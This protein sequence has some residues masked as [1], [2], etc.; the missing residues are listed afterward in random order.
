MAMAM[1]IASAGLG[2]VVVVNNQAAFLVVLLAVGIAA[3]AVPAAAW[4]VAAVVATLTFRGLVQL[5]LLPS[6]ATFADIGFAWGALF[7][8]YLR[9]RGVAADARPVLL[10]L[11]AVGTAAIAAWGFQRS[12]VMR[13]FLYFAL[14]G[15][16][17]ALLGALLLDPPSPRLRR[18]LVRVL[19]ALLAIQIPIAF[20]QLAGHFVSGRGDPVQGTLYGA[21]AG[22]NTMAAIVVVGALWLL[23]ETS[24][25]RM[26][27]RLPL[28][29]LALAVPL[30][31]DAKQVILVLPAGILAFS[32]KRPRTVVLQGLAIAGSV[33]VLFAFAP[34]GAPS[35]LRQ[36]QHGRGGKE[37]TAEFV[38]G[39]LRGDPANVVFGLGPAESV[40][41]AAFMTTPLFLGE[42]SPL[43]VFELRPAAVA[44]EAQARALVV[45]GGGTSFNSG[46]SSALGVLGDLGIAGL[47]AYLALPAWIIRRVRRGSSTLAM[48]AAA[49]WGMFLVL[50]LVYDWWEQPPFVIVL[51]ALTGLAL[52]D[53]GDGMDG[54]DRFR[55]WA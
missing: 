33:V 8:A 10:R 2:L 27:W 47:L 7:V 38:W 55:C 28:A 16:P 35:Y 23:A 21:G 41:R 46:V 42:Q 15:L 36:S 24:G 49:G 51:A 4:A 6:V 3:L 30:V 18:V 40:S 37:A 25:V 48:P 39:K 17:F 34:A 13:P 19:V 29:G 14:L 1:V 43:G 9:R 11:G 44:V 22:A 52:S 53:R 54:G 5:G 31:A 20:A 26:W 32:P 50:G 12:E 45:S